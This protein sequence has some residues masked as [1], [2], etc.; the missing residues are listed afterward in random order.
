MSSI[1]LLT[2]EYLYEFK[3]FFRKTIPNNEAFYIV[4]FFT[5]FFPIILF[6]HSIDPNSHNYPKLFTLSKIIRALVIFNHAPQFSYITLCI[7][8][9]VLLS[10]F[11]ISIAFVFI[12]YYI[13]SRKTDYV[14]YNIPCNSLNLSKRLQFFFKFCIY[15]YIIIIFFYQHILEVFRKGCRI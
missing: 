3:L 5:K 1:S 15:F 6:T 12:R 14:L 2:S 11:M 4:L 8:L 9:Y 10:T 13:A 7:I